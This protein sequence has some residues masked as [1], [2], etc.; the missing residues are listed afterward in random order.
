MRLRMRVPLH[1]LAVLS[2]LLPAVN[3]AAQSL[4]LATDATT[5]PYHALV[6]LTASPV[7]G[8]ITFSD[9]GTPL[10]TVAA[11]T[12]RVAVL[13][14]ATLA[15]GLHTL[16]AGAS[17]PVSVTVT[18]LPAPFQL[19]VDNPI[20]FLDNPLNVTISGLPPRA[21]G[22]FTY[23]D[24]G[25][26][27]ST[28]IIYRSYYQATYQALG[29]SITAGVFLTWPQRYP[30]IFAA[31]TD[32][33]DYLNY[34]ISGDFAC[35]TIAHR[36]LP[37]QVGPTQDVSPLYSL[38]IGTND[39]DS[40]GVPLG[41]A[42]YG[43]CHRA[44]LAW[45]GIP[46]EYKV[47]PGDPGVTILSGPWALPTLSRPH[48]P[49]STSPKPPSTIHPVS[50]PPP[51]PSP[52]TAAHSTSGTSSA[53]TSPGPSPFRSTAPPPEPPTP[54]TPS[55]PLAA[56]TIR[57]PPASPSS[58]SPSPPGP[59]PSASMSPPAPSVSSPPP[60]PLPTVPPARTPPSILPT[61]PTRIRRWPGPPRP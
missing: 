14:V 56:T 5:A 59:T 58:A 2:A 33:G 40:N 52:P 29:D 10:A 50:V 41:E 54:P 39:M 57:I 26:P 38:M 43:D 47:L 31:A 17:N 7:T 23:T 11:G 1:Y 21:T 49:P 12:N 27:L 22:T 20:S 37:N 34:A 16:T 25:V 60:R 36:I 44:T 8:P 9:N 32:F 24:T 42:N 18:T 46:R 28:E 53:I 15:P 35:D 19:T 45:L 30:D 55:P 3:L 61:S 4:T 6:H 51:S 48:P 13:G